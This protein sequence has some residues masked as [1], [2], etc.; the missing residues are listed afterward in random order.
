MAGQINL[1][2]RMSFVIRATHPLSDLSIL[3]ISSTLLATLHSWF[4]NKED[5]K[6]DDC[7][8]VDD[9]LVDN[10]AISPLQSLPYVVKSLL[11]TECIPAIVC[12]DL[13]KF[14]TA[15]CMSLKREIPA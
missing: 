7:V 2:K 9:T 4:R 8:F 5:N 11:T 12:V 3:R 10:E 6:A 1:Q 13:L 14:K 15:R